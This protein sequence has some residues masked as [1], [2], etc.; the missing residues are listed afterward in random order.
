MLGE[1]EEQLEIEEEKQAAEDFDPS[2]AVS[3]ENGVILTTNNVSIGF[4]MPTEIRHYNEIKQDSP[5]LAIMVHDIF[6][7][8]NGR[9]I[10]EFLR[11]TPEEYMVYRS[12][13]DA[14]KVETIQVNGR[15]VLRYKSENLL[16]P[17]GAMGIYSHQYIFATA[18]GNQVLGF[19]VD[20][21]YPNHDNVVCDIDENIIEVLLD[22]CVLP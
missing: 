3:G 11:G 4:T 17:E 8:V 20:V 18:V 2:Q 5:T 7:E 6:T 14:D 15:E 10:V 12:V 16:K 1:E 9:T 21:T 13:K 22:H 19:C